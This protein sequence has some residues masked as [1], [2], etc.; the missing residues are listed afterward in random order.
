MQGWGGVHHAG[1]GEIE[2]GKGKGDIVM[3]P[4]NSRDV[5][6]KNVPGMWWGGVVHAG[7]G[8]VGG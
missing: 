1:V 4:M 6:P 5:L 8:W 7:V 2:K 3:D